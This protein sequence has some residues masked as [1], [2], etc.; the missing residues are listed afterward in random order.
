MKPRRLLAPRDTAALFDRAVEERALAVL[1]L[2]E[3]HGWQS[4][5]SRFLERDPRGRYFVL[6]Y[7][8]E[9]GA[10]P[11][12]VA[13]GQYVGVSFRQRSHKLL[14]ATVVE[15]KGH[16][17]LPD[18][19]TV[20]AVRYRWPDSLTEV[21]RRSYFRTP[22]PAELTLLATLWLG[23]VPAR[24]DAQ[25]TALGIATGELADL[26]CGG[27]LVR[28]HQAVPPDWP[29]DCTLGIE[30]QMPDGRPPL[31]VDVR[32]RGV[33]TDSAGAVNA[34][35]QFIG[36]EVTPDGNLVLQ[37]LAGAVQKLNRLISLEARDPNTKREV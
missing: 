19:T 12:V 23:G 17:L 6:D 35:I 22:V 30:L 13:P 18:R 24:T 36:L 10:P 11:P 32:F 1:T 21:Q 15:A 3:G 16:Y 25:N 7:V 26:S 9:N 28:L 8:D 27:A 37:R 29:T 34:A 4:F 5:K 33:R 2:Q 14:F 31:T 20:P